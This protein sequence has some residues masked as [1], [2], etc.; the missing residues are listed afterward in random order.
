MILNRALAF[1]YCFRPWLCDRT[2]LGAAQARIVNFLFMADRIPEALTWQALARMID[3]TNLRPEA[4]P[5]QIARLCEE[6]CEY[7]FGAVMV[8]GCNVELA[9]ARLRG[10]EVTVGAVIGFPLGATLTSVKKF[11]ASE[12]LK[13][14]AREIDMVINIG[15]LKA[16]QREQ[17]ASDIRAVAEIVHEQKALLKVILETVL[18]TDEEKVT[19]CEI[20]VDSGADFVKT[21]T[22]FLGGGA[23]VADIALMRQTVGNRCGVKASGGIRNAADV[24]AMI[25]AGANRI[26]TSNGV[27]ILGELRE[28]AS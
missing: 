19:A 18:L 26:G 27:S 28:E 20:S 3:H 13:A 6:A 15:A 10:T 8:N 25:S 7:G 17:V 12:A 23:T 21:S 11:E 14:G 2:K 16:G 24:E 5:G 4:T 1:R 22:G 9:C